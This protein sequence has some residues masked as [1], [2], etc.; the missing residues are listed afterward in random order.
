MISAVPAGAL[1]RRFGSRL[2]VAGSLGLCAVTLAVVA[3]NTDS[4]L[5]VIMPWLIAWGLSAGP[6]YVG[7]TRECIG[8]A[9]P[10]DRGTASALFEST[11]HVGGAVSIAAYLP[12][13][14]AGFGYAGVEFIGVAVV[15]AGAIATLLILPG[16]GAPRRQEQAPER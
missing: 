14:G 1:T 5:G 9:A 12:L 7:L 6:V 11:T 2:V 15:A 8:D 10:E 3:F 13:L 4:S 16:P